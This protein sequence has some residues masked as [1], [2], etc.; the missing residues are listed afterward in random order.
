MNPVANVMLNGKG[1]TGGW[2]GWPDDPKMEGLLDKY[3]PR[4]L[5]DEQKQIAV[6]IQKRLYEE[7][8]Y[9]PL[10]QYT[11]P[12]VWRQIADRRARRP[13]DADVLEYRQV[14]VRAG[15]QVVPRYSGAQPAD[16]QRH[17]TAPLLQRRRF[18]WRMQS[19]GYVP[20]TPS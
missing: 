17:P 13:G 20:G 11:A 9:I 5:A 15:R 6:D 7:V 19:L 8:T 4:D 16:T 2:F 10:G 1:K 3:R 12:S 14:G 18:V